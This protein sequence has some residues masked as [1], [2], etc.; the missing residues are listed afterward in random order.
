MK[1]E[2]KPDPAPQV[3][4]IPGTPET[5]WEQINKYGTYNI[6]PTQDRDWDFPAIG[7]DDA[8]KK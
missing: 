7:Q 3:R 1:H 8:P 5:V 2:R 4:D 6:Q